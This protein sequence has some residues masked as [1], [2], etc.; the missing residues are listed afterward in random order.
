MVIKNEWATLITLRAANPVDEVLMTI[1]FNNPNV[2]PSERVI[3]RIVDF[4]F[5]T[6]AK[7]ITVPTPG[8]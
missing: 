3:Q 8:G 4:N 6:E 5:V 1:W 7:T 2:K